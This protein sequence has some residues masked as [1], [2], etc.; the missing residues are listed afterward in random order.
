MLGPALASTD[1]GVVSPCA[2]SRMWMLTSKWGRALFSAASENVHLL[3]CSPADGDGECFICL[4]WPWTVRA[5]VEFVHAEVEV[6][7]AVALVWAFV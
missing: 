5:V 2:G 6:L 3:C 1:S 7:C 4:G